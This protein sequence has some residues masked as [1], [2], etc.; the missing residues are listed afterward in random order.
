[1]VAREK[2]R[3]PWG[4][5]QGRDFESRSKDGLMDVVIEGLF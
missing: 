1:M 5:D 4:W 2:A 3:Q